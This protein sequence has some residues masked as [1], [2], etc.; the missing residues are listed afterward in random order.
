MANP[1]PYKGKHML[2]NDVIIAIYLSSI[3][4]FAIVY[5]I[6]LPRC[7]KRMTPENY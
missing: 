4:S 1:Y 5:S 3:S 7:I 2:I 6:K